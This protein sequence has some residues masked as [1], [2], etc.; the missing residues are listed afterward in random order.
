MKNVFEF[1]RLAA[2]TLVLHF[3]AV[4]SPAQETENPVSPRYG[5]TALEAKALEASLTEHP[6]DLA[7]HEHL[8]SYYFEAGI[9]LH[10]PELEKKREQHVLWLIEHH[11]ES[12]F[13]GSPEALLMPAEAGGSPGGY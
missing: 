9:E 1:L 4:N 8:I 10:A 7:M 3:C 11:P 2:L 12:E 13:A 5:L 6:D